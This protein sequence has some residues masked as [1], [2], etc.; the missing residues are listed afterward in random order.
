MYLSEMDHFI[1]ISY[2]AY[3]YIII[4]ANTVLYFCTINFSKVL[5]AGLVTDYFYT[6]AVIPLLK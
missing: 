5:N 2:T 3:F 4:F 1:I 6:A